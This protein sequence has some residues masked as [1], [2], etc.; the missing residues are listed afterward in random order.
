MLRADPSTLIPSYLE[1]D[2]SDKNVPDLGKDKS[3]IE[4]EDYSDIK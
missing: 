2:R 3:I 4:L 1:V